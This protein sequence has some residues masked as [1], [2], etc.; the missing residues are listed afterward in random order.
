MRFWE[1][2]DIRA[3]YNEIEIFEKYVLCKIKFRIDFT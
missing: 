1:K 2:I 3:I